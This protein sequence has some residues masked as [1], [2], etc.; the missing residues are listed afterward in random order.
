[1]VGCTEETPQPEVIP[2]EVKIPNDAVKM[3]PETDLYPPQ[4]HSAEYHQPVPMVGPINTAGAEDSPFILPGGKTFYFVYVPDVRVPAEKQII[5][6][7]SGMYMSQ[8]TNGVWSEPERVILND[9]ISLDGCHFVQGNILWFCSVREGYTGV[10]WFMAELI[11]GRWQNWQYVGDL[12]DPG[13][14]VGEL[15][16]SA[17][18]AEL[19]YHSSRIGGKGG[20]DIWVTKKVNNKWQA[21][22]NVSAV[23]TAEEEGMPFLSQDMREL[24]FNRRYQGTP[25]IYRSA[26]IDGTWTEPELIISSFA[27]EPSLDNEGNIYFVHHFYREGNMIEA[28]IYIAKRK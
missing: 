26:R 15:H 12:F 10:N 24:W 5:D 21:P 22:E 27:G 25:A 19:Y 17:D 4:L 20:S 8:K 2:R 23:N 18:G 16:I 1:M 6:G 9:D 3:I 13:Y 28:D 11:D 14:E 7:V